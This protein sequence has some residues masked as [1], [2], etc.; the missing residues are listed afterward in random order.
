[1]CRALAI[2]RS[3]GKPSKAIARTLRLPE[4]A[5]GSTAAI[6]RGIILRITLNVRFVTTMSVKLPFEL[7][8]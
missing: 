8:Q 6:F 2:R 7:E 3:V 4:S 1:V 5:L